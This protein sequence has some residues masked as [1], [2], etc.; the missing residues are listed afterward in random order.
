VNW[1]WTADQGRPR[2]GTKETGPNPRVPRIFEDKPARHLCRAAKLCWKNKLLSQKCK[3]PWRRGLFGGPPEPAERAACSSPG[4]KPGEPSQ[5]D[6]EPAKRAASVVGGS[7]SRWVHVAPY[8]AH[9]CFRS[10]TQRWRAGLLHAA[11][12]AGSPSSRLLHSWDTSRKT[13]FKVDL[14]AVTADE[15]R[16]LLNQCQRVAPVFSCYAAW[17]ALAPTEM[18]FREQLAA[19]LRQQAVP[20]G[21]GVP[22]DPPAART[23]RLSAGNLGLNSTGT[24]QGFRHFSGKPTVRPSEADS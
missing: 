13:S 19:S 8:G 22:A 3:R 2:G 20:Q 14:P 10:L 12:F 1:E 23:S 18:A 21:P 24:V 15:R 6:A 4:R 9:L 7:D 16:D 5:T 17:F 11:R